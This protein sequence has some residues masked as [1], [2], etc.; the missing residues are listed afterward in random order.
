MRVI[1]LLLL[2]FALTACSELWTHRNV[3]SG[4]SSSLVDYLYP[5]GEA[6]PDFDGQVPQLKLPLRVGL[7]FVPSSGRSAWHSDHT[8]GEADRNELLELV[9]ERFG[10]REY[11]SRIEIIP[12]TYLRSTRGFEGVS[13]VA[14]LYGVDVMALVSYDQVSST[15]DNKLALTYWTIVGAYVIRGTENEVQ[16][17]VDTAVFDV[18]SRKLLFRAPGI[19]RRERASSAIDSAEKLQAQRAVSFR[20]AVTQMREN[21]ATELDRFED[22]LKEEPQLADVSW[23]D[24]RGGAGGFGPLSLALWFVACLWRRPRRGRAA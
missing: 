14:R 21:L 6:P 22:R 18:R 9:R 2:L 3:R 24:G 13:Q 7:A 4:T 11:I 5:E 10:D 23:R 15:G 1:G 19:D 12:E 16:T 20:A 17:F 8:L